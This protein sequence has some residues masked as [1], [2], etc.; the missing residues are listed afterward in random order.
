MN[1]IVDIKPDDEQACNR[2][3]IIDDDLGDIFLMPKSG[4]D[5]CISEVKQAKFEYKRL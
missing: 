1:R 3:L 2:E 4:I 5:T